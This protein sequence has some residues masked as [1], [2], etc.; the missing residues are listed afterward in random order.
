LRQSG[1]TSLADCFPFFAVPGGR[2]ARPRA[3]PAVAKCDLSR[4]FGRVRIGRQDCGEATPISNAVL[5]NSGT[6]AF[7]VG[8]R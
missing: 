4:F 5:D 2:I 8:I 3:P 7:F 6:D 1:S